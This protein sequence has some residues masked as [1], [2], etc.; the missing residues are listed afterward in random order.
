MPTSNAEQLARLRHHVENDVP[1]AVNQL[2]ELYRDGEDAFGIVKSYKKA[3][4]IFKR[5]VELGNVDAMVSL[6]KLLIDGNGVK[7]P[8]K[9]KAM[10]VYSVAADRGFARA[11]YNIACALDRDQRFEEA[12]R[13]YCLA[14]EQNFTRA[15]FNLGYCYAHGEGTEVDVAKARHWYARAA[16]KGHEGAQG[17]LADIEEIVAELGIKGAQASLES[18]LAASRE[19][20]R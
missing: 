1:E 4:K 2:G 11:Q 6:G 5:A 7:K 17:Y 3:V 8:D 16:A 18:F 15:E 12:F 13:Y 9:K 20:D 14:A 19:P 10:Q